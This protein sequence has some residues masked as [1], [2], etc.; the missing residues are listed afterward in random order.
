MEP[1]LV[2]ISTI[3]GIAVAVITI[4]KFGA[5][6]LMWAANQFVKIMHFFTRY[7]PKTPRETI[8]IIPDLHQCWWHMGSMDKEPCIQVVG[9]F[10]VTNTTD[11]PLKLL[12]AYVVKPRTE[13]HID[14]RHSQ[15]QY[16]G[17]YELLPARATPGSMD[18]W[19]KPPIRKKGQD[20]RVDIVIVDQYDNKHTL[21]K[22]QFLGPKTK[23][24]EPKPPSEAM[25]SITNPIEKDVVGVL[26]AEIHRYKECGRPSGGMGSIQTTFQGNRTMNGVGNESRDTNSPR[27][28]SIVEDVRQ[29]QIASDNAEALGN[30]FYKLGLLQKK[31]VAQ[32]LISRLSRDTEYVSVGYFILFVLFNFDCLS[33]ALNIAKKNLYGGSKGDIDHGFSN[34]LWMLDGLLRFKHPSFTDHQLDEVERFLDGIDE[35]AFRIPERIA[36][37][38]SFRLRASTDSTRS[39]GKILG[40]KITESRDA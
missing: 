3:I 2:L 13:G 5:T 8:K 35:H 7:K 16:Y 14:V 31:E 29:V 18:F 23:K 37:I 19:I 17:G 24:E 36:A 20:F 38:R 28:Q 1:S 25:H 10:H 26:K 4:L 12:R 22:V 11:K 39:R 33:E 21:K 30:L 32:A 27:N 6:I 34:F 9:R 40:E 15:S